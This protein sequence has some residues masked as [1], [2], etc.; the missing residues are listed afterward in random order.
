MTFVHKP[1]SSQWQF[2]KIVIDH[3]SMTIFLNTLESGAPLANRH[4][5]VV[6]DN[7][8]NCHWPVVN[9]NFQIVIDQIETGGDSAF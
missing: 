4:W 2:S 5:P 7:F 9:D 6:N 3:Q 1:I 8:K